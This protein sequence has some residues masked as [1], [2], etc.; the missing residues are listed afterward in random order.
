M[1]R[2]YK[3]INYRKCGDIGIRIIEIISPQKC[4]VPGCRES[5]CYDIQYEKPEGLSFIG[6][7]FCKNHLE[8]IF[9]FPIVESEVQ[10]GDSN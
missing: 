3:P 2:V 9:N 5:E 10:D 8:C 1:M 6:G 7:T 4:N